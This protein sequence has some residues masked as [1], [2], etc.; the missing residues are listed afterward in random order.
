[1][2]EANYVRFRK[3]DYVGGLTGLIE[4]CD[5]FLEKA[6]RGWSRRQEEYG[7]YLLGVLNDV[8]D[9]SWRF[10][11]REREIIERALNLLDCLKREVRKI[12]EN[13]GAREVGKLRELQKEI[14]RVLLDLQGISPPLIALSP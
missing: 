12:I 2:F 13:R 10:S 11:G 14:D 7:K 4:A 6:S 3:Q 9:E 1:M 8:E 5:I